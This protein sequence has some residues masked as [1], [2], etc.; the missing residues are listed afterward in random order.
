MTQRYIDL[1]PSATLAWIGTHPGHP[2][3]QTDQLTL[4]LGSDDDDFK[5]LR[6]KSLENR[7]LGLNP[8]GSFFS[9]IL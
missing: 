9:V 2:G 4:L 8:V 3:N 7:A 6:L 1:R 5:A